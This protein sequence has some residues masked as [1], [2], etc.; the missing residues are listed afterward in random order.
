MNSEP[1]LLIV[2]IFFSLI[3][4]VVS[5]GGL[6]SSNA[7]EDRFLPYIIEHRMQSEQEIFF[8]ENRDT[9]SYSTVVLRN[10]H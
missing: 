8:G 6:T 7:E 1:L 3:G 10:I 5:L 9:S 2:L 4:T